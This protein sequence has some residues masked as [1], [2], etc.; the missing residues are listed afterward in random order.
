MREEG[1]EFCSQRVA[2]PL[3]AAQ[4]LSAAVLCHTDM[5]MLLFLPASIPLQLLL[6][7]PSVPWEAPLSRAAL[8]H[9]LR[10]TADLGIAFARVPC[11]PT[12]FVPAGCWGSALCAGT[13]L[14]RSFQ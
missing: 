4:C 5:S 8:G 10:D 3:G 11:A 6:S 9:L 12:P 1:G 7:S 13:Q 14:I 2:L